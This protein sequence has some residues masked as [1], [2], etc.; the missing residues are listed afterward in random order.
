M[1][2]RGQEGSMVLGGQ[3]GRVPRDQQDMV[4][5]GLEYSTGG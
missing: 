1:V 2:L 5:E 3:E 4:L